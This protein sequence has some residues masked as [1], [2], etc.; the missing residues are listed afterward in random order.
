MYKRAR[1]ACSKRRNERPDANVPR[2][3]VRHFIFIVPAY[4]YH[5]DVIFIV[6]LPTIR[7]YF[8]GWKRAN[9]Q[10]DFAGESAFGYSMVEEGFNRG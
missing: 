8:A 1:F 10:F 4:R 9:F 5:V 3:R 6:D 7:K 2:P